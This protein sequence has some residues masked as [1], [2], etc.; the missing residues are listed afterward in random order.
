MS[1]LV[2]QCTSCRLLG[3]VQTIDV[4]GEHAGLRCASCGKVSWLP[5]TS[6]RATVITSVG[7]SGG[8]PSTSPALPPSTALSMSEAFEEMPSDYDLRPRKPALP[9][10]S[11]ETS[12]AVRGG[13]AIVGGP[14][15]PARLPEATTT[16][17]ALRTAFE[18]LRAHWDDEKA[19]TA[20]VRRA[21][22]EGELAYVGQLYKA[23]LDKNP[24]EPRVKRAQQEILTLAM[25]TMNTSRELSSSPLDGKA[26][27]LPQI[28]AGIF[29]VV[30]TA[31]FL[32][33]IVPKLKTLLGG[34]P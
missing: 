5:V 19:H 33:V 11:P 23:L 9:E 29:F 32:F 6:S 27:K 15:W 21:S 16:Q 22:I 24:S 28:V 30:L 26:S 18:A 2:F 1:A 8:T 12:I 17:L 25:A 7:S 34:L 14:T 20:L 4:D 3:S 13:P 31:V 10:P